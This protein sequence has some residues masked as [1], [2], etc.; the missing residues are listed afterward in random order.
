LY[1]HYTDDFVP[2]RQRFYNNSGPARGD[3]LEI[4][5]QFR[6]QKKQATRKVSVSKPISVKTDVVEKLPPKIVPGIDLNT[7]N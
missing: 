1:V 5:R 7:V 6:L 2:S 4:A 3:A